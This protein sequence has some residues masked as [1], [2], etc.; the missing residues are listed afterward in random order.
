MNKFDGKN[1]EEFFSKFMKVTIYTS[2]FVI[3]LLAA[4]WFFLI[5]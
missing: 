1:H 4:L 5:Y 2:V 3:V